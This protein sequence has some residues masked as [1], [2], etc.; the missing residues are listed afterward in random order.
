MNHP[1]SIDSTTPFVSRAREYVEKGWGVVPLP[2]KQKR[3]RIVGFTG[4]EGKFA[5]EEDITNWLADVQHAKANIAVRVGNMLLVDGTK[6]EAIGIDVDAYKGKNGAKELAAL[7]KRFG[8]LPST[9]ISTSRSDGVSGIRFYLVPYGYGFR[10]KASDSIEIIQRVHR[11]AVVFPSVHPETEGQ[12]YWYEPG[13]A[14]NGVDMSKDIPLAVKLP[15]LPDDWIDYLTDGRRDD[16]EGQ[17]G[18]DLDTKQEDLLQWIAD[19]FNDL[20]EQ[21]PRM[22]AL[23]AK[24]ISDIEA[25][26]SSHDKLTNAQWSLIHEAAEGHSGLVEAIKEVEAVW[27]KDVL[28]RGGKGRTLSVIQGEIRRSRWG[29][30]RKVKAK[31][32]VFEAQGLSF[33]SPELCMNPEDLQPDD[34]SGG[35]KNWVDNVPLDFASDPKD[36]GKNDVEQARHFLSRVGDNIHYIQDYNGWV[37]YDGKT[38]HIDDFALIRDL[39]DRACIQTSE[40]RVGIIKKQAQA[41]IDGAGTTAD[42][43]YKEMLRQ[44]KTLN[45]IIE[46]Y[47]NDSKIKAML[48][49]LKSIPD[50]AMKYNELNWDTSVLAMPDG[51]V[52]RLDEPTGKPQPDAIGWQI[53]D[54]QKEFYTTHSLAVSYEKPSEIRDSEKELWLGYL[55][56]FLPDVSYRRFVQK[57]LGHILIGGNPNKLAIFLVGASNTGKSTMMQAM[58]SMLGDYGATFQPNS[59]FKDGGANNPELGNLLHKRGIFSSESGSQRIHANTFK[60]NCGKDKISVTRKYANEQITGSPHFVTIVGTNQAPIIDDADEATVRRIMVLPFN[61]QIEDEIND[62]RADVVLP[63]ECKRIVL[64]WLIMGYKMY[65]REGLEYDNWHDMAKA[66][67]LDF[68]NELSDVATFLSETVTLAPADIRVKLK[69]K[70]LTL[71]SESLRNEWSQVTS[72]GLYNAYTGTAQGQ[73]MLS[74]RA[75][76]KK[77]RDLLGVELPY[78]G[79]AGTSNNCRRWLGLKWVSEDAMTQIK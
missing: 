24:H 25:S 7:E 40:R 42:A 2:E 8:K 11:Y 35:G 56:L 71:E 64:H 14:P 32:E 61:T 70:V 19:K 78:M 1:R 38:W 20:D 31:A 72:G 46:T 27:E 10:G 43:Q 4:R 6:Y 28:E 23:V 65:I 66:A 77:V 33:F 49:C 26:P 75:F 58:Q 68:A 34:D 9:W 52:F 30:F 63:R 17:Y 57:A 59:V 21:C 39:Y 13:F 29:T 74:D 3:L 41:Y 51:K 79:R 76:G 44:I 73:K 50:V 47:R 54:N 67:T 18:I 53:V 16:S 45:G 48:N 69:T 12:Y 36:F 22:K 62:R 5:G 37:V 15:V 60:R 55:N